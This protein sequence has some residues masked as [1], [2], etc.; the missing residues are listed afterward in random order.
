MTVSIVVL[1]RVVFTGCSVCCSPLTLLSLL[2]PATGVTDV[3]NNY[4]VAIAADGMTKACRYSNV[5]TAQLDRA[6]STCTYLG[7][8]AED[9]IEAH[10]CGRLT[11]AAQE[12]RRAEAEADVGASC[13]SALTCNRSSAGS[14]GD[15]D[16]AGMVGLVCAH[17]FPVRGAFVAMVTDEQHA[18]YEHAFEYLLR[19]RPDVKVVYLDLA[20]RF[21][22]RWEQMVQRL[23]AAGAVTHRAAEIKLLLPWMHAF[24]HN[25]ECQL[26]FSGLYQVRSASAVFFSSLLRP[27]DPR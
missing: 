8:V 3:P 20:C 9:V 4:P 11:S 27:S 24:D 19:K 15:T 5:G 14:R 7:P 12:R 13:T 25:M 6:P 1:T 16:R 21:K 18:Y 2:R 22:K 10:R 17:T 26:Q 23:V